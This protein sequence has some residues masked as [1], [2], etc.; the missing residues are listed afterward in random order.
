MRDLL[1]FN[2]P[3]IVINKDELTQQAKELLFLFNQLAETQKIYM[4]YI[5][6]QLNITNKALS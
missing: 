3:K 2:P 4:E 6:Q 5:K 1:I